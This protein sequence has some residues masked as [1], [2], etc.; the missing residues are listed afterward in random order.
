MENRFDV[1]QFREGNTFLVLIYGEGG[2]LGVGDAVVT[3]FAFGT[4][5]TRTLL[6]LIVDYFETALLFADLIV[7]QAVE[8]T[9]E[10]DIDPF[11]HVLQ[12]LAVNIAEFRVAL[13]P[14]RQ[15][16][17]LVVSRGGFTQ[18]FSVMLTPVQARVVDLPAG[19][20]GIFQQSFLGAGGIDS[21]LE[22]SPEHTL[23][24]PKYVCMTK[25]KDL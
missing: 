7:C 6:Q 10:C 1:R 4:R 18:E 15:S 14:N 16:V 5:R 2:G 12:H 9:L 23:L 17:L 25:Q 21:E 20:E 24:Y 13:F 11:T 22:G 19:G 8:V 3:A